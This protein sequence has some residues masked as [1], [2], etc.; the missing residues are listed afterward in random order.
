MCNGLRGAQWAGRLAKNEGRKKRNG[1]HA[2]K[3]WAAVFVSFPIG[4]CCS[5]NIHN[6]LEGEASQ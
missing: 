2:L 5:A 6:H 1:R 4:N 3:K